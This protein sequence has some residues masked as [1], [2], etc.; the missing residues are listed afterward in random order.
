[1]CTKSRFRSA[2]AFAQSDQN[3]CWAVFGWS[4]LQCFF[5][6]RTKTLIRLR[7]C[8]GW[9]TSSLNAR[10]KYTYSRYCPFHCYLSPQE[11]LYRY[12]TAPAFAS[13]LKIT[14]KF[15]SDQV[16]YFSF[17]GISDYHF[18]LCFAFVF[19]CCCG[20]FFFFFFFFVC[21]FYFVLFFV[22]FFFSFSFLFFFF[23]FFLGGGGGGVVCFFICVS[24]N[25][26][27][28]RKFICKVER[29]SAKRRRSRWDGSLWAVSSGSTLFAKAYYY[30][31]LWQW[32]S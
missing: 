22:F 4:G 29:L 17:G 31:R 18:I 19:C 2:C 13:V 30:Y 1:M 21:L 7:G 10:Q 24:T 23:F 16:D 8:I 12:L 28:G 11:I 5:M 25:L 20:F 32:K 14:H 27:I 26:S 3:L 15:Y 9:S 6:R